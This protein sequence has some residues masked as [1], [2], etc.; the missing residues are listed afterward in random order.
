MPNRLPTSPDTLGPNQ[1]LM[2]IAVEKFV[3]MA[4]PDAAISYVD[5]A[6]TNESGWSQ[7]TVSETSVARQPAVSHASATRMMM[8]DRSRVSAARSHGGNRI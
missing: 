6:A 4:G 1:L 7:R 3:A 8:R 5:A 2:P